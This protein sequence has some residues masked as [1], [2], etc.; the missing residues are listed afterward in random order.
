MP[1]EKEPTVKEILA[2]LEADSYETK[3]A[4]TTLTEGLVKEKREITTYKIVAQ[5]IRRELEL[6]YTEINVRGDLNLGVGKVSIGEGE[7]ENP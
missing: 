6:E 2:K 4:I 7:R 5:L 3:K 1:K